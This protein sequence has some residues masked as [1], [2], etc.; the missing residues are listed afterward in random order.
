MFGNEM[1]LISFV[2]ILSSRNGTEGTNFDMRNTVNARIKMFGYML[3][4]GVA[5]GGGGGTTSTRQQIG[6]LLSQSATLDWLK[7]TTEETKI[8]FLNN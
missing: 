1:H 3:V 4:R 2:V 7:I 8:D 5:T 6:K